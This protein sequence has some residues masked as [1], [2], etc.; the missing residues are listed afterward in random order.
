MKQPDDM[1]TLDNA[2]EWIRSHWAMQPSAPLRLHDH[3]VQPDDLLGAP[4]LSGAFWHHLNLHG[5]AIESI[6]VTQT[7]YHPRLQRDA[8]GE[9]GFYVRDCPDCLG[10]GVVTITRERYAYPMKDALEALARANERRALRLIYQLAGQ[11][12]YLRDMAPASTL[13]AIR[14]LYRRFSETPIGRVP[15]WTEM[16]EAQQNAMDAA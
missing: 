3:A 1:A 4:K 11:S 10:D 5:N 13:T 2:I 15:K 14:K 16:S 8:A 7:C 12:W 6:S 9:V